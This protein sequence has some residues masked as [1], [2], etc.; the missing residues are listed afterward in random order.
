[1][2]SPYWLENFLYFFQAGFKSAKEGKIFSLHLIFNIFCLL[3]FLGHFRIFNPDLVS[4]LI[5]IIKNDRTA[6]ILS[7]LAT[8]ET[9]WKYQKH[10]IAKKLYSNMKYV[11]PLEL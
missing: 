6:D 8:Y 1:M 7:A 4:Y 5:K 3:F 10:F 9:S 11:F 2:K